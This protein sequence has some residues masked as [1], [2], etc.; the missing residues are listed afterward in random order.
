MC[1]LI[2]SSDDG[3]VRSDLRITVLKTT[4]EFDYVIK[5]CESLLS[6]FSRFW[7]SFSPFFCISLFLL[8]RARARCVSLSLLLPPPTTHQGGEDLAM[9]WTMMM[10]K[11]CLLNVCGDVQ[12]D[13]SIKPSESWTD[14]F[15]FVSTLNKACVGKKRKERERIEF[16]WR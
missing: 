2:S 9:F 1:A 14:A 3:C 15:L 5:S 12:E 16:R 8:L 13:R 7:G 11:T 6:F 10:K 4:R